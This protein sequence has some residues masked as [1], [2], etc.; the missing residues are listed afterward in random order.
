MG[1]EADG[2]PGS[3]LVGPEAFVEIDARDIRGGEKS[4]E[5]IKKGVPVRVEIG[6]RDLEKGSVA[7]ARRVGTRPALDL[8]DVRAEIAQRA[9]DERPRPTHG[10]IHDPHSGERRAGALLDCATALKLVP[11]FLVV[12]FAARREGRAARAAGQAVNGAAR[13]RGAAGR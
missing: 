13:G 2:G 7:V 3:E 9:R 4:W 11:G 1:N 12:L 6:L 5:W 10:E 8:H